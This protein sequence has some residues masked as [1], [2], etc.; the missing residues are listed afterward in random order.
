MLNTPGS[1][2]QAIGQP[3]I[4]G[5]KVVPV[6]C[7]RCGGNY[8]GYTQ[9]GSR[10]YRCNRS[11]WGS[12]STGQ[13]CV[14]GALPAAALEAAVWSAVTNAIQEPQ[15]L[16]EEYQRLLEASNL[17]NGLEHERQ[18]VTLAL[19]RARLQEDR[20]T[21]AYVNEAMDLNRYK[22]EMD[23]LRARIQELEG[24]SRDLDRKSALE[25]EAQS[26]LQ[27][28]QTFCHTVAEGLETMSFEERQELLRMVVDQ[29]TVEDETVRIET[30]IP[31]PADGGQLHN[32][33][34]VCLLNH[35]GATSVTQPFGSLR[36]KV[37]RFSCPTDNSQGLECNC[38]E[39]NGWRVDASWPSVA[40][41]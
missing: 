25:Q 2:S 35:E 11:H 38:A 39:P 36:T 15:V 31:S 41:G 26:G 18:Q 14:P 12:S 22:K 10:G 20:V 9:R 33:F 40:S 8:T 27:Y 28:L 19:K 4:L 6:R 7:P 32:P 5:D 24:I 17:G 30:V 34:V 3:L 16:I 37:S 1:G 21:Q 29:V 23:R 13:K